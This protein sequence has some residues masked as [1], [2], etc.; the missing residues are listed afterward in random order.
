MYRTSESFEKMSH[1]LHAL[2]CMDCGKR[3]K[4]RLSGKERTKCP[5]CGGTYIDAEIHIV[6]RR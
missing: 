6:R 5:R 2:M 1:I 3:F 4:A